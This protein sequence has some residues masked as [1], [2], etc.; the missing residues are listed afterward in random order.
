[1]K[2]INLFYVNIKTLHVRNQRSDFEQENSIPD[3]IKMKN[4]ECYVVAHYNAFDSCLNLQ[5]I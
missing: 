4:S 3:K 1:M 2:W 5:S